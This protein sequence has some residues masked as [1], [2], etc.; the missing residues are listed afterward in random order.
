M[1]DEYSYK[2]FM[3]AINIVKMNDAIKILKS[4]A[5]SLRIMLYIY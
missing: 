5:S 2:F 1:E 3:N 4:I